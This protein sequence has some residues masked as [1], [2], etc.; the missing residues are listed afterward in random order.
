VADWVHGISSVLT[1]E[2]QSQFNFTGLTYQQSFLISYY[3]GVQQPNQSLSILNSPGEN[4]LV[5]ER[6]GTNIT[7]T[8]NNTVVLSKTDYTEQLTVPAVRPWNVRALD[9]ATVELLEVPVGYSFSS[10]L[11]PSNISLSNN[12]RTAENT[13]V[14]NYTSAPVVPSIMLNSS[15]KVYSE[16]TVEN[17]AASTII[18]FGAFFRTGDPTVSDL[19]S[20]SSVTIPGGYVPPQSRIVYQGGAVYVGTSAVVTFGVIASNMV[21]GLGI[22]L[23]ANT[24]FVTK[25]GVKVGSDFSITA[26]LPG[27]DR[28]FFAVGPNQVGEKFTINETPVYTL[29]SGYEYIG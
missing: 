5:I 11:I 26:A 17:V 6:T 12:N 14:I 28:V 1:E 25:D 13:Q 20:P 4:T 2:S 18:A 19:V 29:P 3:R 8:L 23:V 16:F 22:D 24:A 10:S 15:R 9:S 21:V 7:F 27:S